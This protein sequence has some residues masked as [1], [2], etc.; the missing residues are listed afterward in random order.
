MADGAWQDW[1][2]RSQTLRD[3]VA[4]FPARALA[5]T[6]NHANGQA[7]TEGDALPAIWTWMN[8]LPLSLMSEVAPDGHPRRGG[9]LPPIDLPRR[10]WA[11]SRCAFEAPVRIGDS[12]ERTSTI[13]KIVEKSGAAGPMVLLTM[14]HEVRANGVVAM[15]EEQDL[16]FIAIAERFT[17]PAPVPLPPCDWREAIAIDPVMLFRFSALTFNGHRIHYDRSYATEV[18]RYPGLVVHGPLQA[19]LLFDAAL[20]RGPKGARPAHLQ[21]RGMRP[22]FDFDAITLNGRTDENGELHLYTANGEDLIGMQARVRW[23][24]A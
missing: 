15:R 22:L 23:T 6:L 20:R 1:V 10:M 17:P 3:T 12:I 2:G 24:T 4:A 19:I 9:F 18:E 5:L 14:A 21:F 8:F 11:G 7:L 13:T 16:A